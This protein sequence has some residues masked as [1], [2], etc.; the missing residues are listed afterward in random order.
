M[1]NVR[2]R[3][4]AAIFGSDFF[5]SCGCK[6][7]CGPLGDVASVGLRPPDFPD[8]D[9]KNVPRLLALFVGEGAWGGASV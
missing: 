9:L 4:E 1:T 3:R 5:L 6:G 7:R 8:I 2:M